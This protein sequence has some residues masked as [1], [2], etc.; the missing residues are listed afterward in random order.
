MALQ[1]MTAICYF[2]LASVDFKKLEHPY[3]MGFILVVHLSTFLIKA[4]FDL[5][6]VATPET[7]PKKHR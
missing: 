1:I 4:S 5:A 7:F 2:V 6:W 3:E